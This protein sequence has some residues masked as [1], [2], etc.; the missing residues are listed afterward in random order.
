[1]CFSRDQPPLTGAWP[2]G[3]TPQIRELLL[4]RTQG[5]CEPEEMTNGDYK[6]HFPLLAKWLSPS[7]GLSGQH[8]SAEEQKPTGASLREPRISTLE[9]RILFPQ[10]LFH[11]TPSCDKYTESCRRKDKGS[12]GSGV[13]PC[14]RSVP[15]AEREAP[16]GRGLLRLLKG[17]GPPRGGRGWRAL[18]P[19]EPWTRPASRFSF[20]SARARR[21]GDSTSLPRGGAGDGTPILTALL[22]VTWLE[23]ACPKQEQFWVTLKIF[24]RRSL[25]KS[26]FLA[27]IN[28]HENVPRSGPLGRPALCSRPRPGLPHRPAGRLH[29]LARTVSV[30]RPWPCVSWFSHIAAC[31][32][33]L[34]RRTDHVRRLVSATGYSCTWL[35]EGYPCTRSPTGTWSHFSRF[36]IHTASAVLSHVWDGA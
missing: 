27:Q 33:I 22:L 36:K 4:R 21:G 31:T 26:S 18:D 17:C 15:R 10:Q 16:A 30:A 7:A 3:S 24:G 23:P 28:S 6:C 9:P 29:R 32:V 8:D 1:M 14:H 25:E 20:L 19:T 2:G 13:K 12:K 11:R 34:R 5:A 35:G